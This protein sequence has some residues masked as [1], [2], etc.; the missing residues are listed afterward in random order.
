ML[1]TFMPHVD[2]KPRVPETTKDEVVQK[3]TLRG[4]VWVFCMYFALTINQIAHYGI[5]DPT[6]AS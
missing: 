1:H 2:D 3:F 6:A 5:G 4:Y